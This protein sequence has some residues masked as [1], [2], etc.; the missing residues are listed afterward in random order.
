M[1]GGVNN[2]TVLLRGGSRDGETTTV[3]VGVRRLL[4]A[5]QA[6]GL[7]DVYEEATGDAAEPGGDGGATVF[8][9][10]DDASAPGGDEGATV[11]VFVGQEPAGDLAPE[12]QHAPASTPPRDPATDPRTDQ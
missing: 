2:V 4:A 12:L 3:D 7:I 5:S 11:F 1:S 10:N 6:P 9:D 8:G